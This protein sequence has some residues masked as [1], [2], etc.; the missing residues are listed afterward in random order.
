MCYSTICRKYVLVS[1][2]KVHEYSLMIKLVVIK[3]SKSTT[4][5]KELNL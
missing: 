1:A 4:I 5:Y 3:Q 2:K